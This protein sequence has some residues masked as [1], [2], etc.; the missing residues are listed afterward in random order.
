MT[1][2]VTDEQLDDYYSQVK[3]AVIPL[4]FGAGV[5]GKTVEAVYNKVPVLTTSVGAEGI[6]NS[7]GVLSIEDE[8]DAFAA[9]LIEL[10][11]NDNEL[12]RISNMS[13]DF[14]KKQFTK[15]IAI[16]I[17]NRYLVK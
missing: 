17:F 8:T 13:C 16:D 1:G 4:N 12:Q 11:T 14:I 7:M 5:K 9:R 2:F 6:D 10:Y 15:E 3:L